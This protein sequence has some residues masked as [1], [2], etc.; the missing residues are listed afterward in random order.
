MRAVCS[1][2]QTGAQRGRLK[3]SSDDGPRT[4]GAARLLVGAHG[5]DD[6]RGARHVLNPVNCRGCACCRLAESAISKTAV[7]GRLSAPR[8]RTRS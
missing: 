2:A 7:L 4:T 8:L 6:R 5:V 3:S 1:E